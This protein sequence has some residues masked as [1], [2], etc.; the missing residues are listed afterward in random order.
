MSFIVFTFAF[1]PETQ[2]GTFAGNC[3]PMAALSI[4]Q[5]LIV[6]SMVQQQGKQE[7]EVSSV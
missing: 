2:E 5:Q 7:K 4:L 3:E 1:N 6:A